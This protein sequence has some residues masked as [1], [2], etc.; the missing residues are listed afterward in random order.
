MEITWDAGEMGCGQLIMELKKR[1]DVLAPGETISLTTQDA[2]APIDLA[3]WC[4]VTGHSLE[5][6]TQPVYV[7]RRRA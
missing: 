1:V 5:S 2:G 7:I 3:A 6:A 4:R